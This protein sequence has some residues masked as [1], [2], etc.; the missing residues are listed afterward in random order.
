M[1]QLPCMSYVASRGAWDPDELG[2]HRAVI[3]V[4]PEANGDVVGVRIPW[5]RRDPAPEEKGVLLFSRIGRRVED[6][7]PVT[8]TQSVGEFLFNPVDGPGRYYL[9]FLPYTGTVE[10]PYPVVE[11]LPAGT[12]DA[13]DGGAVAGASGGESTWR[14]RSAT[15]TLAEVPA[16]RL[17]ALESIDEFNRFTDMELTAT[18]DEV[19]ALFARRPDARFFVFPEERTSPIRMFD[20]LPYRWVSAGPAAELVAG[21]A[22][23]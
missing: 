9:Y 17:V 5:R 20:A 12:E 18:P 21:R 15:R 10:K 3:E 11:Y 23:R 14:A 13:A 1:E 19:E 4:S 16:A 2:N 22:A 6:V 8:V 7:A